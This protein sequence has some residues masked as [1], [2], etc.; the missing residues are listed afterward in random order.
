MYYRK[1]ILGHFKKRTSEVSSTNELP[2]ATDQ[3]PNDQLQAPVFRSR[4]PYP[5]QLRG[6]PSETP[7]WVSLDEGLLQEPSEM[8]LGGLG[9]GV[10][11]PRNKLPYDWRL[12]F[13]GVAAR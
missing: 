2:S 13:L 6:W 3:I 8:G 5:F 12:P 10:D 1:F 11:Y 9:Q 7:R 4:V